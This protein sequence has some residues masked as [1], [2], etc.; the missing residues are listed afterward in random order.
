MLRSKLHELRDDLVVTSDPCATQPIH[1]HLLVCQ[2]VGVSHYADAYLLA[3]FALEFRRHLFAQSRNLIPRQNVSAFERFAPL[4]Q[5]VQLGLQFQPLLLQ[6]LKF[7]HLL[8]ERCTLSSVLA[9]CLIECCQ[10]GQ[11]AG[12]TRLGRG[13]ALAGFSDRSLGTAN[14]IAD[15]RYMP[16]NCP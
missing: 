6:T 14:L 16:F 4:Q 5:C 1:K 9:G 2:M 10:P 11:L 3:G 13:D 15:R 7:G 12:M 8:L